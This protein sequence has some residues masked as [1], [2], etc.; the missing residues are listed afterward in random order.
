[1]ICWLDMPKLGDMGV[2]GGST[3]GLEVFPKRSRNGRDELGLERGDVILL[4][5]AGIGA[6]RRAGGIILEAFLLGLTAVAP[7]AEFFSCLRSC[8]RP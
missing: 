7:A 4:P 6:D 5:V 1:M 2:E 3:T 8:S